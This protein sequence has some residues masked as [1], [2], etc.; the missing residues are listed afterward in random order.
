MVTNTR[1]G[2]GLAQSQQT[3]VKIYWPLYHRFSTQV[4]DVLMLMISLSMPCRLVRSLHYLVSFEKLRGRPMLSE[5]SLPRLSVVLS[6]LNSWRWYWGHEAI[7]LLTA[8]HLALVFLLMLDINPVVAGAHAAAY[9]KKYTMQMEAVWHDILAQMMMKQRYKA[10]MILLGLITIHLKMMTNLNLLITL[11]CPQNLPVLPFLHPLL[12]MIPQL[13]PPKWDAK[14]PHPFPQLALQFIIP[15]LRFDNVYLP[16][17]CVHIS[18]L[19]FGCHNLYFCSVCFG[20]QFCR[21]LSL[22]CLT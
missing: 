9:A 12:R 17:L 7:K 1:T 2:L 21:S 19:C 15:V 16:F 13:C 11:R 10:T 18:H 20:C 6:M 4:C 14:L 5:I 3:T 22:L 8:V